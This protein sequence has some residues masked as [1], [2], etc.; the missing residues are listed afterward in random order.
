MAEIKWIKLDK[1]IFNNRK[2][3]QIEKMQKGDTIIVIWLKLLTLAG[4]INDGGQIYLARDIPYTE[5]MLAAE[6]G[7]PVNT[8]RL[9]LETFKRFEMICIMDGL[10]W[11]RNWERYQNVEGMEK[12]REQNRNRKQ[13]QRDRGRDAATDKNITSRDSHV[14][15]RDSHA[16][17]ED[18][19][20]DKE[21]DKDIEAKKDK[22]IESRASG[23][24][25]LGDIE[26]YCQK[27]GLTV[28][29]YAFWKTFE[30]RGWVQDGEPVRNWKAM[31]KAWERAK[32]T[33]AG[34]PGDDRTKEV[35]CR[36][37][38]YDPTEP[39]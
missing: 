15:E 34:K 2:I 10:I 33:V 23:G 28:N 35:L 21:E 24:P 8:V 1:D 25:A 38:R 6:F 27:E 3:R 19:D 22:D 31:L 17:E 26:M 13:A 30:E 9:A 5:E 37:V 39:G 36:E 16:T 32:R 18:K 7:R 12:V 14:T 29:P 4:T 20:K 11:I